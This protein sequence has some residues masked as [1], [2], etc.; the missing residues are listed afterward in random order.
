MSTG[1]KD[2]IRVRGAVR[3]VEVLVLISINGDDEVADAIVCGL[4]LRRVEGLEVDTLDIMT[5]PPLW[6]E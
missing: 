5:L 3:I 4:P 6:T 1:R 2:E